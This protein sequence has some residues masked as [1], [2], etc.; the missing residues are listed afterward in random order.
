MGVHARSLLQAAA[1]VALIARRWPIANQIAHLP[2][3]PIRPPPVRRQQPLPAPRPSA[4]MAPRDLEFF[5]GFGGFDKDGREYVTILDS[6]HA[7]PDRKST[8]LNSSH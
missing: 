4:A 2:Q 1:R 6:G 5:N 3:S 7:T 8:R